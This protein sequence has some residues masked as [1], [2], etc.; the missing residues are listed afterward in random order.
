MCICLPFLHVVLNV[1]VP[2]QASEIMILYVCLLPSCRV[3]ELW[4]E[5]LAKTNAKAAQSL[6]DPTEYENL[7]PELKQAL[8]AEEF[9]KRGSL[10]PAATFTSVPVSLHQTISLSLSHSHSLSLYNVMHILSF[11]TRIPVIVM[12]LRSLLRV[13]LRCLSRLLCQNKT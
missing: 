13:C 11:F 5:D 6:A 7:F 4:R 8:Q 3:V 10:L 12:F 9:L 1:Q 2:F